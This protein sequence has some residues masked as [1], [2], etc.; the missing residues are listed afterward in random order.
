MYV[1]IVV[2][3]VM[4]VCG[5]MAVCGAKIVN[6]LDILLPSELLDFNPLTSYFFS[7]PAGDSNVRSLCTSEIPSMYR[8]QQNPE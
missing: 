2:G 3:A 6:K 4:M 7:V 8:K 1:V 5:V